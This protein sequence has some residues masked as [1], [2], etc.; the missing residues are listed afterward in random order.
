MTKHE[1]T[2]WGWVNGLPQVSPQFHWEEPIYWDDGQFGF[3]IEVLP[4]TPARVHP[5]GEGEGHLSDVF[6]EDRDDRDACRNGHRSKALPG[7]LSKIENDKQWFHLDP[8]SIG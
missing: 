2:T 7:N 4:Q 8:H 1:K 5:A 3:L 6:R